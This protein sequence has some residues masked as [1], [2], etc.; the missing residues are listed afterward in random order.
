MDDNAPINNLSTI[1]WW[2]KGRE[3]NSC[4][5]CWWW[6]ICDS[7]IPIKGFVDIIQ[8]IHYQDHP[9]WKDKMVSTNRMVIK[10]RMSSDILSSIYHVAILLNQLSEYSLSQIVH[11]FQEE[12]PRNDISI[13]EGDISIEANHSSWDIITTICGRMEDWKDH[14]ILDH[15]S[16][17][18]FV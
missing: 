16:S 1:K 10:W 17:S 5:L 8:D 2:S 14:R 7:T 6:T 9:S 13:I 3:D 18:P 11:L 15:T 12:Y 4:L